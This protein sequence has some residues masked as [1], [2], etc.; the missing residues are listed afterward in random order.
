MSFRLKTFLGVGLIQV[1]LLGFMI[2]TSLQ[3]LRSS[4]E[5]ELM[6]RAETTVELLASMTADAVVSLDLAT[7]DAL[8]EK[9]LNNEGLLY[10][11]IRNNN[12][13]VL[14][15]GGDTSV[16]LSRPFEN[17]Q[18]LAADDDRIDIQ[19]PILVGGANFGTVAI[20]LST[21]VLNHVLAAGTKRMVAIAAAVVV[22]V[23]VF[24]FLLGSFLTRNL[25]RLKDG[26]QKVA[27]GDFGYQIEINGKDEMAVTADAFNQMSR[28]LAEYAD[29]AESE[30]DMAEARRLFAES[31]LHNAINS[32]PQAVFITDENGRL[33]FVNRTAMSVY[34]LFS[35]NPVTGCAFQ[36]VVLRLVANAPSSIGESAQKLLEERLQRFETQTEQ[37]WQSAWPDGRVMMH[38]QRPVPSGGMVMVDTDVTELYQANEK[39]RLLQQE[40][41]ETHKLESLGTLAS[42]VAHEINT[43]TQFIGD[44]L[45]FLRGAFEDVMGFVDKL[46]ELD[47]AGVLAELEELDWE[48]LKEEIPAALSE[49]GD[50]VASIGKIV[51]SIKE[52][53]HPDDS[54][55]Q[56]VDL[57][58]LVETAATVARSQ[59]RHA[60]DLKIEASEPDMTIPCYP[61]DISQVVINLIVNAA[62][63]IGEYAQ[64]HDYETGKGE[65]RVQLSKTHDSC[66]IKVIDNG[67]GMDAATARR[68]FDM[69]FTTKAPGKGTGQGLSICKS[70]VELKHKGRLSVRSAPGKGAEFT[71]QLPV[72]PLVAEHASPSAG[73]AA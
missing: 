47:R 43:P 53:A 73:K 38:T 48:F 33:T 8:V 30:R 59:W 66:F 39:N 31:L 2:V 10:I 19:A 15:E 29:Q 6:T 26:A 22:L 64:T 40:L 58:R 24:G 69:F 16:L 21:D 55:K 72:E 54:E 12:G 37:T 60:A 5:R 20:G 35:D 50:G 7:L 44:N 27:A 32:V 46:P 68:I 4:N 18:N 49:A 34:G 71:I 25:Y 11:Q 61:G 62:D 9:G 57:E 13:L 17:E 67:P 42:G 63:A 65:I 51:H 23:A 41:M 45:K 28:A 52:F 14:S 56:E 36:D 70:I 1:V 3:D